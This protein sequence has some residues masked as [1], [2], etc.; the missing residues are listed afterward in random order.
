MGDYVGKALDHCL[1]MGVARAILAGQMG[2]VCKLAQ[3]EVHTHARKASI[4]LSMLAGLARSA[5]AP[6]AVAA[7]ISQGT[8]ARYAWELSQG[9]PWQRAFLD[10]LCLK[11]A[12]TAKEHLKGGKMKI[13]SWLFD[14]D[15][16]ELIG[17]AE[18][19]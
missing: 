12:G 1:K 2:K 8:T 17:K 6:E 11:A 7:Q 15:K 18:L 4:D 10:S 5:G 16:G 14:F 13:E 9:Q 3:G 19:E